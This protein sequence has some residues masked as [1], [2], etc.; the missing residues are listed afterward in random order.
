MINEHRQRVMDSIDAIG[1]QTEEMSR[2]FYR[3]LFHRDIGLKR[4]F[5]GNV[6][7]LNRKFI[8]MLSTFTQVEHLE[9]ISASVEK[10]GE[11]H[12]QNYGALIEHFDLFEDALIHALKYHFKND[13][14][15]ELEQSWRIVFADVAAIMK[16]MVPDSAQAVNN[17]KDIEVPPDFLERIGGFE[18]VLQVHTRFYEV[19]F[20]DPWL[21]QY[22]YGKHE[23]VLAQKQTEFMVAAFGGPNDY[24][25]DTPAFVHMH[26]FI[27]DEVA[28]FREKLLRDAILAEGL[29][30][31]DADIWLSVDSSF[32]PSIVKQDLS[33]CV[34]KCRGQMPINPRK[35]EIYQ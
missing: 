35:P 3:E 5:P 26:M 22:F 7:T 20:A 16:T 4:V 23:S 28:D 21:G 33:E 8:N 2:E 11:R 6:V 12:F 18:R 15:G 32:R 30:D 31:A 9:K 13:F 25:G 10:M 19:M 14:S 1:S 29:T 27:S 24:T 17:D 34:M